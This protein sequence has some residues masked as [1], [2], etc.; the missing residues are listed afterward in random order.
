V[1][2]SGGID[3]YDLPVFVGGRRLGLVPIAVALALGLASCGGSSDSPRSLPP[4]STTPTTTQSTQPTQ[5][6]KAE[7]V[8]VVREYFHAKNAAVASM[9]ES[10]LDPLLTSGCPC[11]KFLRSI[12]HT[13]QAGNRYFGS[14]RMKAATPTVDSASSIEVLASYDTTRG[15]TKDSSG[16]V[17]FSGPARR[18]LTALFNVRLTGN[19]WLIADIVTLKSGH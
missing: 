16:R 2:C 3:R 7:A 17:L 10:L 4:L 6:P 1:G 18:N 5:A 11:R 15:G 9:N 19:A 14:S 12:R 13:R 8:A